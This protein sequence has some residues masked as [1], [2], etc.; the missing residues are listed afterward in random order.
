MKS[1]YRFYFGVPASSTQGRLFSRM[2]TARGFSLSQSHSGQNDFLKVNRM[3][4]KESQGGGRFWNFSTVLEVAREDRVWI[5]D[6]A[7]MWAV[8]SSS[9]KWWHWPRWAYSLLSYLM[10]LWW[11]KSLSHQSPNHYTWGRLPKSTANTHPRTGALGWL[12]SGPLG[13]VVTLT[14]DM[15]YESTNLN[16]S[17]AFTKHFSYAKR[18]T[19][20]LIYILTMY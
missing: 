6:V 12:C 3:R 19:Y 10:D 15:F 11:W 18:L 9:K 8:I 7:S 1:A 17:G 4:I 14:L 13:L 5:S 16:G 20:H 2:G